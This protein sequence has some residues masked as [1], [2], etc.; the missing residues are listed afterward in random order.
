MEILRS[1]AA[2]QLYVEKLG[3]GSC[4]NKY[5]WKWQKGR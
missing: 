3:N 2:L 5:R 1:K 4:N